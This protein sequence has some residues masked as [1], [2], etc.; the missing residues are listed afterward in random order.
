[1]G[2]MRGAMN[3]AGNG[4]GGPGGKGGEGS[5]AV[6]VPTVY[7]LDE[8]GKS[9]TSAVAGGVVRPGMR[10]ADDDSTVRIV[11]PIQRGKADDE[12]ESKGEKR[13][14]GNIFG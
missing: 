3:R 1:M 5:G 9:S 6:E 10:T 13:G 2:G 11:S 7:K 14:L 4:P 8:V 12:E